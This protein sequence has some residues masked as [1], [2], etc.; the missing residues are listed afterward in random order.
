MDAEQIEAMEASIQE[1]LRA[2]EAMEGLPKEVEAEMEPIE[3]SS[4]E[5]AKSVAS[6]GDHHHAQPASLTDYEDHSSP[7][8]HASYAMS[9]PEIPRPPRKAKYAYV[10]PRYM[11]VERSPLFI[12]HREEQMLRRREL[13]QF[14]NLRAQQR[15]EAWEMLLRQKQEAE[16]KERQ[17]IQ[18]RNMDAHSF[19]QMMKTPSSFTKEEDTRHSMP[20]RMSLSSVRSF[21]PNSAKMAPAV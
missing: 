14:N 9:Q 2:M 6:S 10:R 18:D 12:R 5:E 20:A 11:D 1:K 7:M 3:E 8:H 19:R 4:T 15:K 21:R 16:A 17:V 13:E